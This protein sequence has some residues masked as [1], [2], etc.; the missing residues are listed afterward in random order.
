MECKLIIAFGMAKILLLLFYYIFIQG[1]IISKIGRSKFKS[2]LQI[3]SDGFMMIH[4]KLGQWSR[5]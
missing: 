3:F 5:R 2:V 4:L 1:P